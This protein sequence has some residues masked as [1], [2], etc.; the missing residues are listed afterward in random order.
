MYYNPGM[1]LRAKIPKTVPLTIQ[2]L[3]V[4]WLIYVLIFTLFRVSTVFLFRPSGITFSSLLPSF[5]LGFR[6]DVKWISMILLPIALLSVYAKFSP[7]FSERNKRWWSYYLAIVTLIVLFFFGAD[8]GNFS[9]NHTRI[10]ASALNF[11]EDPVISFKMLWQSYPM[12]WILVAL[13]LT[14]VLM[15]NVFKRTHVQTLKRNIRENTIYKKRWHAA[16]VLFLCWCLFGIFSFKPLRWKDAFD[17]ND[18]FKSYVALNPLQNFF[19][20]LQFR[21]PSFDEQK[22]KEYFPVIAN[23][24]QL[25]SSIIVDRNYKREIL[26]NSK[27]LESRPNVILVIAES[28]S[29][30]KSSMSGNPL[31]TTPFFKSLCDSGLFFNRCFSPTFGTARGVFAV[32]TGTPDVQLSKFSTRNPEAI[33]QHTIINDFEDYNKFYF[34]G[35]SS[36]FNNFEGLVKNIDEVHLYQ[37]GSF[38][39]ALLNVWGISDKNLFLEAGNVFSKEKKPFFAVIQTADNHRPYS[40]PPEDTD[41]EKR[42]VSEDTLKKYGFESLIEFQSFCYTDYC[43]KKLIEEGKKQSW[44]NNTIFVF[45]GDH[46]V[47][48]ESSAMYPEAWTAGQLTDEHVPMLFYAPELITPQT[49]NEVVSQI[50]VLPTLAGMLHQPYTNTTL[51][52]DLLNTKNKMDAAFIIHHD[53]GNIGVVTNDYYYVK[54]LRIN[55]EELMP[56]ESNFLYISSQQKDSVKLALSQLTS[57]I[58]ETA[59]WMLVNNK[60]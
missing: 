35:G 22:A 29:M 56:L 53:E 15:A 30:Y 59:K 39:S 36:E 27:A 14:V 48:G 51:G 52:R 11:V 47:E 40:I 54:N 37:E 58:Y 57:A 12:F 46:G 10:N 2:W 24:L 43:F 21:K 9:Y 28:F 45:I 13:I 18:N 25:D 60:K 1:I 44:F 17:L 4:L 42:I 33:Q 23:F 55:K 41:F 5:W 38:K 6:F 50:D 26:P 20:T 19:T 34:L 8:F 49:R 16:A 32:L 7:F 3:L 31:N